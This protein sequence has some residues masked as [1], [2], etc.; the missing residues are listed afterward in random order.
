MNQKLEKLLSYDVNNELFKL[1]D[2]LHAIKL[3]SKSF[4]KNPHQ[5]RKKT[6]KFILPE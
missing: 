2:Q 6:V 1:N 4:R 5:E 3:K